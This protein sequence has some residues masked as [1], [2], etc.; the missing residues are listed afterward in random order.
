MTDIPGF[1]DQLDARQHGILENGIE[2][3]RVAVE[4]AVLLAGQGRRQVEAEPVDMHF[5]DPVAKRIHDQLQDP[6]AMEVQAVPASGEIVVEARIIAPQLVVGR[7]VDTAKAEGRP[8]LVPLGGMVVDDVQDDL[9]PRL[10]QNLDHGLELAEQAVAHIERMR[11]EEGDGIVAP[12]VS[13]A[14]A[15]QDM[16]V[17]EAVDRQKFDGR[18]AEIAQVAHHGGIGQRGERAARPRFDIGMLLGEPAHMHLVDDAFVPA[19]RGRTVV[20]PGEGRLDDHAFQH[21]GGIV[22]GVVGQIALGIAHA[23]AVMGVGPAQRARQSP[24][25]GIEQQLV[26]VEAMAP[27]RIVGSVDPVA[28]D[29]PGAGVRQ[30]AVPDL[31]GVFHQRNPLDFLLAGLVE[32]AQVH[33]FGVFREQRE[34]HPPAVPVRPQRIGFTGPDARTAHDSSS[35]TRRKIAVPSGG[36]RRLTE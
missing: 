20:P 27:R 11:R 14:L 15:H 33:A 26:M 25:V 12:I 9:D 8:H 10:V 22:A 18:D 32:Q 24:G 31:V 21:V 13:K 29:L 4:F 3:P 5:L 7:I 35:A 6:L 1:R 30:I 36:R 28:V 16:I 17:D 23:I 2:E 19:C 34:I